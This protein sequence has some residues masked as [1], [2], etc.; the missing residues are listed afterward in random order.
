M[1]ISW[2]GL[3]RYSG[4]TLYTGKIIEPRGKIFV[5]YDLSEDGA[6]RLKWLDY[7][8]HHGR[9]AR[10]TCRYFGISPRTFYKAKQRFEIYGY[11]GLNSKSRRPK[12]FR[13]SKIPLEVISEVV[14]IRDKYPAWSKY[15][16]AVV[17]KRDKNINLS[18]S[19]VGRILKKKGKIDENISKKKRKN[20][21]K[22][23][24]RIR[25]G[26]EVFKLQ[27]PGDL[28]Q[29]D[30]KE[31]RYPW[32]EK[33]YQ[34]SA[35]DCVS[36]LRVLRLYTTLS[37]RNGKGFLKEVIRFY[38][39]KIKRIQSD[40]GSEFLGEFKKECE[41]VKIKHYFSYPDSPEQNAFIEAAHSTDEREFYRVKELPVDLEEARQSLK[42]WENVYNNIRPHQ[43]LGYLS[44]QE[45]FEKIICKN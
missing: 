35:I 13:K 44:P 22:P 4:C 12:R 41:K 10:L 19:S 15:K 40:N 7:Y 33:K 23:K 9:N 24:T 1:V 38:P 34:Y 17:L 20:A 27:E 5:I 21:L 28:I 18:A 11:R 45:Y 16:I 36:K 31:Y 29:T 37:S 26:E 25:I 43:A 2:K 14:K 32:G 42:E 6:K 3:K 8:N 39:F 30:T